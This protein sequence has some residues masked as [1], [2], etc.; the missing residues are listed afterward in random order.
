M[1]STSLSNHFLIAMPRMADPNFFQTVNYICEHTEDGALGI[2]VNRPTNITL[3]EVLKQMGIPVR[4]PQ[5]SKQ[6]IYDGG[7]VRQDRGFILHSP[8]EKWQS[9]LYIDNDV[10]LTT[11]RDILEAIAAGE[12]PDHHLIA[13]GYAGWGAH[14]LEEELGANAWLTCKSNADILFHTPYK[15]RWAAAAKLLGVDLALLIDD[16]GHA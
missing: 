15:A 4:D 8:A 13:L 3:G 7:P 2:T 12:G 1:D 16:A 14:Q 11:S 6:I 5:I 9:S 10:A